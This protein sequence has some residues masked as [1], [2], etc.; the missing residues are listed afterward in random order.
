MSGQRCCSMRSGLRATWRRFV[1]CEP[2]EPHN[3]SP[4]PPPRTFQMREAKHRDTSARAEVQ[5]LREA[6]ESSQATLQAVTAAH[7]RCEAQL[8]AKD[9][10]VE[11]MKRKV[12][13]LRAWMVVSYTPDTPHPTG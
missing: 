9:V 13:W 7:S 10:A 2:Y 12:A 3:P 6:L 8:A 5:R 1:A 4:Y 11:R